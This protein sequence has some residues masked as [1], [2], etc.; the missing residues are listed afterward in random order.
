LAQ[1]VDAARSRIHTELRSLNG[2]IKECNSECEYVNDMAREIGEYRA[3]DL[4]PLFAAL[5][6]IDAD[7]TSTGPDWRAA[8]SF[9]VACAQSMVAPYH[10]GARWAEPE[11]QARRRAEAEKQQRE[12]A[13]HYARMSREQEDRQ[14]AEEK[15]RFA[16]SRRSP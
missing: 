1:E 6:T 9:A 5:R 13:E 12:I 10:P 15:E 7:E 2:R 11:V 3:L 16:A 4:L 8:N 14:N